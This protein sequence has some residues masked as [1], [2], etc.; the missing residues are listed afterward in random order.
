[1]SIVENIQL[2]CR[3]NGISV[4]MLEKELGLSRGSVYR[5]D[6]NSPSVD[7]LQRVANYFR[8]RLDDIVGR[9]DIF[10]TGWAIKE[11]RERQGITLEEMS[12]AIKI[13]PDILK[14]Y[15]LD[16]FPLTT[17]TLEDIVSLFQMSVPEFLVEYEL[18]N[19][20]IPEHFKGDVDK[21]LE[22]KKAELNDMAAET[23]Q[24]Y[25][26]ETIAAHH[27]SDNWTEEELEEIE[28]FKEF[29]KS[30]RNHD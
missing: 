11:E 2:L 13:A 7:K 24:S 30:K 20:E 26:V 1:M 25:K 10:N 14:K 28:R 4:P 15:E 16:E 8:V 6:K 29:L 27:D 5:W 22:F 23:K 17:E 12:E 3:K 9:G 18:W 21:Y 19:E